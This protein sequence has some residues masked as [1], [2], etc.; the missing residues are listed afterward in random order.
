MGLGSYNT[1]I[2]ALNKAI[3]TW[4]ASKNTTDSPIWVVDQYTGFSGSSDLRDGVH[5]ND[6]GDTKMA[7][8]WYPALVNALQVAQAGKQSTRDI[9]VAFTA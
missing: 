3:P 4:A 5:P 8:V 2:Q 7:N 6:S 1:Q 9:E